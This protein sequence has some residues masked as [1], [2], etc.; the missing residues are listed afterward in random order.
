[1]GLVGNVVVVEKK[2]EV[3]NPEMFLRVLLHIKKVVRLILYRENSQKETQMGRLGISYLTSLFP[4][5]RAVKWS[6]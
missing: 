2:M 3:R 4:A 6:A 5:R 1:M